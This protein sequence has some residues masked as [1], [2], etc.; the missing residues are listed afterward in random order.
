MRHFICFASLLLSLSLYAL[1][2]AQIIGLYPD[3]AP[4]SNGYSASD[5]YVKN[6]TKI[7]QIAEPRLDIYQPEKASIGRAINKSHPM[8]L[9]VSLSDV[10]MILPSK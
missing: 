8:H 6:E 9:P 4:D 7:Y 2:P 5:E 1:T 3:G 10:R